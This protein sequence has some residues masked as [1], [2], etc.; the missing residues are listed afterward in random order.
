MR[1]QHHVIK[2]NTF[3]KLF[4]RLSF[5]KKEEKL[6]GLGASI[7]KGDSLIEIVLKNKNCL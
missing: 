2:S 3:L 5:N 4:Y 6:N 7:S 1:G